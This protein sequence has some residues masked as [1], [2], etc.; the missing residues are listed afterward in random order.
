MGGRDEAKHLIFVPPSAAILGRKN[1]T[2][3]GIWRYLHDFSYEVRNNQYYVRAQ[4]R[5]CV[6]ARRRIWYASKTPEERAHH[7]RYTYVKR[8]EGME[9]NG[10][11]RV[12][13]WP[14]RKY[15]LEQLSVGVTVEQLAFQLDIDPRHVLDLAQ[16]YRAD[17]TC[18]LR[19]IRTVTANLIAHFAA[20][21]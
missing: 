18:G 12:D 17:S 21:V 9:A 8:V 20:R 19:P 3:C 5:I 15:L 11:R 4:C 14:I 1:C 10:N 16:G 2:K 13:A 6:N 7:N